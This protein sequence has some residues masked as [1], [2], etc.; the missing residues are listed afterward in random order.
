MIRNYYEIIVSILLDLM[1]F[2]NSP[3]VFHTTQFSLR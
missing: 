2:V 1:G 3:L